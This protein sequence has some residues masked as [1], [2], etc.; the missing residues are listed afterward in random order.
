MSS[1][2]PN[3][4]DDYGRSPRQEPAVELEHRDAHSSRGR[5]IS[6]RESVVGSAA[7][8][9]HGRESPDNYDY[10]G[11]SPTPVN[12]APDYPHDSD[13]PI[14]SL[15]INRHGSV[16]PTKPVL[17]ASSS[18]RR[19]LR[20]LHIFMISISAAIGM[21]LYIRT[22]EMFAL[23]GSGAVIYAFAFLGFVTSLVMHNV[24]T[25]L[26]AWPIAGA[27]IVFVQ[28]FIDHEIG[29]AVG[30]LYW[31]AYCFSFA[32][33]TTEIR[34]IA[35]PVVHTKGGIAITF[36]ATLLPILINLTD[37]RYFRRIEVFFGSL[38]ITL[39]CIIAI[40]MNAINPHVGSF[41]QTPAP[42]ALVAGRDVT[43]IDSG[44]GTG[45]WFSFLLISIYIGSF[46]FVG[47]EAVAAT[48]H[49][50][51]LQY[52]PQGGSV[53]DFVGLQRNEPVVGTIDDG[54]PADQH[55]PQERM[56]KNAGD[57]FRGPARWVPIV[58]CFLY[59]WN[60]W[61]VTSNVDWADSHL[62]NLNA[63]STT[64]SSI[65]VVAA[66]KKS[67]SLA[68]AITALL[69]I[70]LCSTSST[71]LYIASRTLFGMAYTVRKAYE[72][73]D[74][75]GM[76]RVR[77]ARLLSKKNQF[78]VPW[79]AVMASSL[80]IVWYPFI[81]YVP[82]AK[83]SNAIDVIVEMGSVC[84]IMV[85]ALQSFAAFRLY[86]CYRK[87]YHKFQFEGVDRNSTIRVD[88]GQWYLLHRITSLAAGV[89][90]TCIAVVGGALTWDYNSSMK[91]SGTVPQGMPA[92]LILVL[93]ALVTITL[94]FIRRHEKS[95]GFWSRRT[96]FTTN[97]DEDNVITIL[98]EL[99]D[100]DRHR[101]KVI[102]RPPISKWDFWGILWMR[103]TVSKWIGTMRH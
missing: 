92:V 33:L 30:V 29:V 60:S 63:T 22:G 76:S 68:T 37:I 13:G 35:E 86:G 56:A 91:L 3:P 10:H 79:V 4:W 85:W 87:Y 16:A 18:L 55:E 1:S 6:P 57:I 99:N 45:S 24:A 48:A 75:S 69:I 54:T 26:S 46:G 32:G 78:D 93:F 43:F 62:P 42:G 28:K 50:A 84:C 102:P 73:N 65:F 41:P 90:C 51:Q 83:A 44:G 98:R 96:W 17:P 27:L 7:G 12:S 53:G 64:G 77:V 52:N 71:S 61:S 80:W 89:L 25:M 95:H 74:K 94:K 40:M 39:A 97:L 70:N 8:S 20:G 81:T 47:V 101:N 15:G 49:E 88:D 36:F 9:E 59:I 66:E 67:S 38:K 34:S 23:G 100:H 5:E 58:A 82:Y 11:F 72:S 31:L 2:S 21:G 14:P 103:G 19:E